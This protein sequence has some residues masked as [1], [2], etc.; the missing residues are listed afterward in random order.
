MGNC[1]VLGKC[2]THSCLQGVSLTAAGGPPAPSGAGWVLIIS[3][4]FPRYSGELF[5]PAAVL[6]VLCILCVFFPKLLN[7]LREYLFC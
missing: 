3:R 6:T 1:A 5:F 7:V 2:P 4:P